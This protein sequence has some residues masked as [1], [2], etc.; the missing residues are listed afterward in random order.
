MELNVGDKVKLKNSTINYRGEEFK[1][2]EK[3]EIIELLDKHYPDC[4]NIR[5]DF[6]GKKLIPFNDSFNKI[7][8]DE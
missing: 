1:R 3:G 5:V 2:G 7:K 8:E 4:F 6:N